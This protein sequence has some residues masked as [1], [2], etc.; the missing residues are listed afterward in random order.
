MPGHSQDA[1]ERRRRAQ[2]RV[3]PGIPASATASRSATVEWTRSGRRGFTRFIL[4]YSSPHLRAAV[5][6][7]PETTLAHYGRA[8]TCIT[9]RESTTAP[10]RGAFTSGE[11]PRGEVEASGQAGPRERSAARDVTPA[12]AV[13][14]LAGGAA[15]AAQRALKRR[16]PRPPPRQ[17]LGAP[18]VRGRG[19]AAATATRRF[20][21]DQSPIAGPGST[22]SAHLSRQRGHL[23][24]RLS[25]AQ[26]LR[27][28]PTAPQLAL[29]RSRRHAQSP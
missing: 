27:R 1:P 21:L 8:Y 12:S 25:T 5:A 3:N 26:P 4:Q 17:G 7:E 10:P 6:P 15:L 13:V 16:P 23:P 29:V 2:A 24:L 11:A 22:S 9:G 19:R 18:A 28:A 14:V 20:P